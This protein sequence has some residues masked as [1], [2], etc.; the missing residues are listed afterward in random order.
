MFNA[1]GLYRVDLTD[2]GLLDEQ[3]HFYKAISPQYWCLVNCNRSVLV[4]PPFLSESR[5][6]IVQAASPRSERFN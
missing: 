6:F 4:V 5:A 3:A 2:I 1:D